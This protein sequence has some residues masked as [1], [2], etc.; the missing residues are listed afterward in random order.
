MSKPRRVRLGQQLLP[1]FAPLVLLG[2]SYAVNFVGLD[3][4]TYTYSVQDTKGFIAV[5]ADSLNPDP[6]RLAFRDSSKAWLAGLAK[7]PI[8]TNTRNGSDLR[9]AN[10][11]NGSVVAGFVTTEGRA[12]SAPNQYGITKL[13]V[14]CIASNGS[15]AI[16]KF[17]PPP[18]PLLSPAM[19]PPPPPPPPPPSPAPPP[20]KKPKPS[21]RPRSTPPSPVSSQPPLRL[22]PLLSRSPP[23]RML[24]PPPRHK[25]SPSPALTGPRTA[26][27]AA[28]PAFTASVDVGTW[29]DG[30]VWRDDEAK[31]AFPWAW[32]V[33]GWRAICANGQNQM[34]ERSVLV[35]I[36]QSLLL[37]AT[38]HFAR[39]VEKRR[40]GVD[41][42]ARENT[43]SGVFVFPRHH[44]LRVNISQS[45]HQPPFTALWPTRMHQEF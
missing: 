8:G 27:T 1:A 44:V 15:A 42:G 9:S 11:P 45:H 41:V 31:S 37:P 35:I 39:I 23:S 17:P 13:D 6:T 20:P 32:V 21:P 14:Y 12:N 19:P 16:T 28:A 29:S 5:R 40:F 18:P 24:S 2:L 38:P 4:G 36:F 3:V 34:I 10:C 33:G 30:L 43:L 26:F 22:P 25:P 7:L